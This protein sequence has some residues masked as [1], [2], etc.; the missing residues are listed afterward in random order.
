M[1]YSLPA[2]FLFDAQKI[3]GLTTHY[4]LDPA[5]LTQ[6]LVETTGS[7]TKKYVPGLAQFT[8]GVWA[9]QL[10]DGLGSVRQ[11]TDPAG[12]IALMQ[13]YDPFG[14]PT[15]IVGNP[16][17]VFG[18]TGEQV[19]PTGL[20]FLRARYYNPRVG[21]FL[22]K[23]PWPGNPLRSQSLNGFSYVEGN[24]VT[25]VDPSGYLG[26]EG[27]GSSGDVAVMEVSNCLEG[28]L[29]GRG[30]PGAGVLLLP[31][32]LAAIYGA[33]QLGAWVGEGLPPFNLLPPGAYSQPTTPP[34][35]TS[36]RPCFDRPVYWPTGGAYWTVWNTLPFPFVPP[37]VGPVVPE[38]YN[39]PIPL[40]NIT[41]AKPGKPKSQEAQK[42]EFE[43][44]LH[45]IKK[46]LGRPLTR[47]ERQQLHWEISGKDYGWREIVQEALQMFG[48]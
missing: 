6:V 48:E 21:R 1:A 7:Q 10:P 16:P 8:G 11:L 24:P 46:Q 15:Q 14:N 45:E 36:I 39:N 28:S 20:V 47:T 41:Y 26:C 4:A 40:P 37:R 43:R 18:Y 44:A 42:R 2:L 22:S 34:F 31:L 12:Q 30:N 19:D 17:S 25:F 35:G 29:G 27:F 3:N 32:G 13:S 33:A 23:D 9:Y 5:G 38:F